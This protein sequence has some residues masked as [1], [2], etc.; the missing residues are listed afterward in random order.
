MKSII[1]TPLTPEA[2]IGFK[3]YYFDCEQKN[4]KKWGMNVFQFKASERVAKMYLVTENFPNK[5]I[6]SV[7]E[8]KGIAY[9][10][11]DKVKLN[12]L[13]LFKSIYDVNEDE[14]SVEV[15]DDS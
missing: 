4:F 15:K 9:I 8:G 11:L 3:D 5:I 6:V 2:E 7:K 10:D 13:K 1:F 14:I 12:T